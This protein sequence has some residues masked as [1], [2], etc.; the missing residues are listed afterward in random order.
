MKKNILL[1]IMTMVL[2][3]LLPLA[4]LE[5]ILHFLPV[6][7][8]PRNVPIGA[9]NPIYHRVPNQDFVISHGWSFDIVAKKRS[10]NYGFISRQDYHPDTAT[11]LLAIIGD[12]QV[13]GGFVQDDLTMD[14]RLQ[15]IVGTHG[16]VYSFGFG[17]LQ[18]P[19]YLA[20]ARYARQNFRP[21]GMVFVIVGNDYD[22]S[23]SIFNN[24][25][26]FYFFY[27]TEDGK[28]TWKLNPYR[29]NIDDRILRYSALYRYFKNNLNGVAQIEYVRG[30]INTLLSPEKTSSKAIATYARDTTKDTNPDPERVHWSKKGVD[31]FLRLLPETTGLPPGK[32]LLVVEG[33]SYPEDL[34]KPFAFPDMMREYL[35]RQAQQTG[36]ETIDLQA[37]FIENY[38]RHQ[39]RFEFPKDSHWSGVGHQVIAEQIENSRL[40]KTLLS[41]P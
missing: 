6:S 1:G 11:P 23:I 27:P 12:S 40:F 35:L 7:S 33:R 41:K 29:L 22:E 31:E 39:K 14:G 34:A 38:R 24:K 28:L 36:Y 20:Y 4:A 30:K 21:D 26:N 5:L 3:I 15:K 37:V 9:N 2:A 19:M 32:I 10:N 13:E 18:L 17:G 25:P 16:R 8:P